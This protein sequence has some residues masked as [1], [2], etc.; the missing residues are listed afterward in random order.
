MTRA[1]IAQLQEL[2]K[3][4]NL[5][6]WDANFVRGWLTIPEERWGK[7]EKQIFRRLAHLY[8]HQIAAMRKNRQA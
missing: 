2:A 6:R 4:W 8:R 7:L 3:C 5:P 1:Q